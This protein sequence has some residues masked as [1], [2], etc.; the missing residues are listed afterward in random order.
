[1]R[2]TVRRIAILSAITTVSVAL[3][4]GV[5]SA[6]DTEVPEPSSFTSMFTAM[7]TPDMVV[8][9]DGVATPGEEGATGTFNYRI[10]SDE[11]IICYDITL[12]GVT[13]PYESPA[14]T[15]TH[16]HEGTAGMA[17]PPRIAFPNP[18][19][20]GSG[21]LRSEGC[22][23]GPFTTGVAPE[24]TDTGEGFSLA[25]IEADPSS[26]F[27]DSHTANFTAG[28]VRGQLTSVPMGGV[29]TGAGGAASENW[30]PVALG[31]AALVGAA[32]VGTLV[33]RRRAQD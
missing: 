2:P 21:A 30:A 5:A 26:F 8:N 27:T 1:M 25:Q 13:P 17:G 24:G 32:G 33:A 19:D 4:A 16:I 6:Q 28:A 20:D 22:L 11:E 15:A 18:E 12:N 9:A 29:A 31:A 14:R 3:S 7:A 10:N 23:Q